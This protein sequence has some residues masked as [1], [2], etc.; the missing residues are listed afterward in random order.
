MIT[1]KTMSGTLTLYCNMCKTMSK[2]L[3]HYS[4]SCKTLSKT[5]ASTGV[6]LNFPSKLNITVWSCF[7]NFIPMLSNSQYRRL[8]TNA[9]CTI[10]ADE[11]ESKEHIFRE[12]LVT[13]I[14]ARI[15]L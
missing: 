9:L 12:C 14:L 3:N 2:T 6:L 13:T 5:E 15:K 1:C 7:M 11:V 10:C 4:I 8:T